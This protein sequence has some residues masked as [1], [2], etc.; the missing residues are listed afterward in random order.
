MPRRSPFTAGN[1]FLLDV[2]NAEETHLQE[3]MMMI[4]SLGEEELQL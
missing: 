3:M 4:S 1:P 2:S